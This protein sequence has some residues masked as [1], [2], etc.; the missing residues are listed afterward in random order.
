MVADNGRFRISSWMAAYLKYG[1]FGLR[2]KKFLLST[3]YFQ[4]LLGD[5][6]TYDWDEEAEKTHWMPLDEYRAFGCAPCANDTRFFQAATGFWLGHGELFDH[7]ELYASPSIISWRFSEEAFHLMS[8]MDEYA[9]LTAQTMRQFR[10]SIDLDLWVQVA[11]R[12]RMQRPEFTMFDPWRDPFGDIEFVV[13]TFFK[14][15]NNKRALEASLQRFADLL[16]YSFRVGYRQ[17]GA[18]PGFTEA[19]VRIQH[20]GT[21]WPA[22]RLEKFPPRTK[23]TKITPS[24]AI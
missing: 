15:K 2:E 13:P 24:K 7:L 19:I 6:P 9:L 11:L 1:G 5:W 8:L 4:H 17:G 10:T 3:I 14:L 16:G 23:V 20:S 22:R 21:K 12:H 18:K